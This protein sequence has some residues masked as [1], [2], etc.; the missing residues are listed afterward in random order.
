MMSRSMAEVDIATAPVDSDFLHERSG[1]RYQTYR[2]GNELRQRESL[3][4]IEGSD[5]VVLADFP[6]KYVVGSGHFSR[7]YL[8]E[9]DGFTVEAPATW[10]AAKPTPSDA[11]IRSN[12]CLTICRNSVSTRRSGLDGFRKVAWG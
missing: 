12:I 3:T 11:Y 1:R 10:F 9:I 5:D 2:Q 4:G 6:L 7:T 8:A